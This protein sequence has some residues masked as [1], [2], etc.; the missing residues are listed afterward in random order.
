MTIC[1]LY[2]S[3]A[4]SELKASNLTDPYLLTFNNICCIFTYSKNKPLPSTGANK[5][6]ST[7]D[8]RTGSPDP[9]QPGMALI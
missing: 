4:A 3:V 7:V 8:K 6:R 1:S 2:Y 9:M 5:P